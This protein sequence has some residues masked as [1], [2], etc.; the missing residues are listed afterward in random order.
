[1]TDTILIKPVKDLMESSFIDYAMSVITDRA[2]PDVRDGLKPVHRRI[3]YA[4]HVAGNDYNKPYKK[5]AR[6]V[7]DVIGKYHPHGDAS[8]YGAAVRMAQDFS[9]NHTLIDGQGNFGSIDG[10]NAAA[11]R[12]TEMRLSRLAGEMFADINKETI[13]WHPN[14]DGSEKEPDALPAPYPNLVVNGVEG[15]AVGMASSL[16]PHNLR[17]VCEATKLLIDDRDT[18]VEVLLGVLKGPDFPTQAQVFEL[19]GF[20]EAMNT[21]RGRVRLRA[22]WHE[23]PRKR[24]GVSLVITE[25]PY[26]VN[27]ANLV[28]KIAD[29][30]RNKD[31]EDITGLRDESNKDGIR[32][33]IE[34][35]AGTPADVIFAQLAARTDLE[36]SVS[37][38]CVVLDKGIPRQMGLR[39]VLLRW[40]V[41]RE[42]VVLKRHEYERRK[43][44]ARL[45]I[46][47]GLINALDRLDEVIALIRAA[48]NAAGA[49][50]GLIELLGIDDIQAQ[51]ILDMKLQK[52]TG[53]EIQDL[54]LEHEGVVAKVANLTAIIE[55]PERIRGIIKDELN[56][57]IHRYGV[58]RRTELAPHLG[59]L[60]R[61]DLIP[62]EH[63]ILTLTQNGYIKRIPSS[64][65]GA[66]NR[67]T[68]GKRLLDFGQEDSLRA[69][70][71]CE[72]H[73]LLM[74]FTASGQVY[75]RKAY[76][77]PEGSVN[78]KGRHF[79][80]IIEGLDED[81]TNLLALPESDPGLSVLTIT[82]SGQVKRTLVSD[83]T[84]AT[85]KTGIKGVKLGEDDSLLAAF[86]VKDDDELVLIS[87]AGRGI[88]FSASEVRVMG[89][90]TG[91]VRGIQMAD[92]EVLLG[93]VRVSAGENAESEVIT[94]GEHG[95]GK[96]TSVSEFP[97]QHRGGKGVI[98]FKPNTKT[99]RL[100][101]A[102]GAKEGQDLILVASNGVSNRLRVED[103]RRSSRATS[104]VI[105]M[106]LDDG[107]NLTMAS[108][109]LRLEDEQIEE[110]VEGVE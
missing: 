52:L 87:N 109:A 78:N 82:R 18:A 81:I 48:D 94:I 93:A 105:L 30:V 3:L 24:G 47:E 29:L 101:A 28:A 39:D 89:R 25:L 14:Y 58:D 45:H 90:A 12:Y 70:Y 72:S 102:I 46:L 40:I 60:D 22:R 77:I 91:G 97:L 51:A 43:A 92:N 49:R 57:I 17:E 99:G 96:R 27:K 66:Q 21:G 7:G 79:R 36:T 67:G 26:Q 88:R 75:A 106:N 38:N 1:M 4:M 54:R 100:I 53:L 83:Y 73:D 63:V 84:G 13:A 80:N 98:S 23:E 9:M 35:K 62:R 59:T 110:L 86:A 44:Q 71:S 56:D 33:V 108:T 32:V 34:I 11:M 104:G 95:I 50:E 74:A 19:G 31:V 76:F 2:L 65:L 61:E 107:H 16:P 37:Y 64:S 55:S 5:S 69:I 8:V 15:I 68:R 6:M 41:F 103:I 20:A 42:D 10:D 85:R